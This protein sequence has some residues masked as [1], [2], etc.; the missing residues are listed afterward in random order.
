MIAPGNVTTARQ[1]DRNDNLVSQVDSLGRR[2][3]MKYDPTFNQLLSLVD[4]LGLA[5]SFR[6]D[7]RGNAQELI[8]TDGSAQHFG[9]DLNG[10]VK[11]AVNRRGQ[12]IRFTR[13]A[14][15]L[16][17]RVDHADGS[18]EDYS[19]DARGNLLTATDGDGTTTLEYTDPIN[20]DLL[21]MVTYPSGR[22]LQFT[23]DT[24]GRRIRTVDQS[25]FTVNYAYDSAGRLERL[26]DGGGDLIVSYHYDIVGRLDRKELGNGTSTTYEYDAAGQ[27]LHL[28]NRASDGSI[29]SRF[30]YTYDG[31]GRRTSQITLEGTTTYG[32]DA[33]GQLTSVALPSGRIIRYAY[34]ANGNRLTV[35][36]NGT[37]TPYTANNLNQYTAVGTATYTYDTDGNL[38]S[39]TQGGQTTHYAYDD[40]NRLVSLVSSAGVWT[41][42]YDALG[43]R[44]ATVHDGQRTEYLVDPTGLGD[45]A[46]EYDDDG[47]LVVQYVHGGDGLISRVDTTGQAVYYDFDAIGSTVGLSS[48]TGDYVNQYSYLPFGEQLSASESVANPYT[49]VGKYGVMRE[50][51][52]LDFMRARYYSSGDGRFVQADPIGISGGVNLYRYVSNRPTSL[53]DP[54]G[55]QPEDLTKVLGRAVT[56]I[57]Y[58][59]RT[60][61][62]A[63]EAHV[64]DGLNYFQLHKDVTLKLPVV[65]QAGRTLLYYAGRLA[66]VYHIGAPIAAGVIMAFELA[67]LGFAYFRPDIAEE[68][69]GLTLD[70]KPLQYRVIGIGKSGTLQLAAIDPNDIIG[71]AGF[72][73]DH[74][75]RPEETLPYTIHFENKASASAA[76]QEVCVTHQLDPD[77]DFST[78]ELGDFGFGEIVG[79]VPD[80]L[81]SVSARIDAR[82]ELGYFVDVA[83]N[84]DFTTGLVTWVFTA[85][86]PVTFDLP[87]DPFG[88]F[89]PPNQMPPIGEGFV[90]YRIRP[91]PGSANGT[92]IDSMA[93][94]V[95][96][97]EP[98]LDTPP[99][100]NTIDADAPTSNVAPL[101]AT[102]QATFNVTW[103][104][105]DPSG[106]GIATFDV[107]VSIDGGA[108]TLWRDDTP[109]LSDQ[110]VGEVGH[111]Y[112]FYSVATD[113]V[114]HLEVAPF[115]ADATTRTVPADAAPPKITATVIQNGL[116]QRSYLDKL[117]FNFSEEVNLAALIAN[118][119][120]TSVVTLT[121][122]GVNADFEADQSVVLA[123][124][125]FRYEFEAN[126]GLSR[127]TWSLDSFAG[128]HMSLG[129]GFYRLTLDADMLRDLAG[130]PLD[131]DGNGTSGDDFVLSFHRLQ[132][133]ADGNM[134]VNTNDTDVVNAALGAMLNS[135]NWNA[136]AD[137]DRDNRITVR[138][139]VLVA[140]AAGNE[141]VP[142]GP[143]SA[144]VAASLPGDFN[145][146][147]VVDAADYV[148]WR[149]NLGQAPSPE[150]LYGDATGDGAVDGA[151]HAIWMQN[152]GRSL[153]ENAERTGNHAAAAAVAANVE[154]LMASPMVAG[155]GATYDRYGD[156]QG[157]GAS[158]AIELPATKRFSNIIAHD[159]VFTEF[160]NTSSRDRQIHFSP[161][162][163]S[164]F[165]QRP[166]LSHLDAVVQGR[167]LNMALD[168]AF[169]EDRND[170][171]PIRR[172]FDRDDELFERGAVEAF[173]KE[174]GHEVELALL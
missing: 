46:G 163:R 158:H 120:I 91:K 61:P 115:A 37:L 107:F 152:F 116:S 169:G 13:D 88:G 118:G 60:L 148:V 22:S 73:D 134:A 170:S 65:V 96:D 99:I 164:I 109:N 82:E 119:S 20:P 78:F 3:D 81:S 85:V 43:N 66:P 33:T 146:N 44:V 122:L 121:N 70:V 49:Y 34:D 10:E 45:V 149:K 31:L 162:R 67:W 7:A 47:N 5:T 108:F 100:I 27:L 150:G 4:P 123:P 42:E 23:Y 114:G 24:G 25:G 63:V 64:R 35:D 160:E 94:I 55:L 145:Q 52:G 19:Y 126:S 32:Y 86:D 138:D 124:S 11:Q 137:L 12:P 142:P 80:G 133:D 30:D 84:I 18:H 172:T 154:T 14:R 111:T 2:V 59:R 8:Y 69:A 156:W 38:L 87:T 48:A 53:V 16:V 153:G 117:Q 26:T 165:S 103:G 113:N 131:G 127:I 40:F 57:N 157:R 161:L 92:R 166:A 77:L 17:T 51:S 68:F 58:A 95:F 102:S 93:T 136:N 21:T 110:Y 15:G 104:G 141:I 140:R 79:D 75:V 155:V 159:R 41:Y 62:P 174:D 173:A 71:P 135:P 9:F 1:F 144:V 105:A 132:G 56:L 130:H 125:Q 29:N 129:D 147:G 72:G 112:A 76:A 168:H 39:K 151:D 106:S 143:A 171:R 139:R 36:D 90:S 54:L 101:S 128:A 98:P 167:Q 28:V 50:T 89:L 6:R 97:V 74:F 83:A